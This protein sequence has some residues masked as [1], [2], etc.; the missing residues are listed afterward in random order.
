MLYL[1]RYFHPK[2]GIS[3]SLKRLNE[4]QYHRLRREIF[5]DRTPSGGGLERIATR[6]LASQYLQRVSVSPN[7]ETG[8]I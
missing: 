2:N 6:D 7:E 3:Q 1:R 8:T 4:A 5:A